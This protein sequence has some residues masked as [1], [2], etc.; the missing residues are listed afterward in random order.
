MAIAAAPEMAS[1]SPAAAG[2][3]AGG[4][5]LRVVTGKHAGE[6]AALDGANTMVGTPG[7]DTALVVRRARGFFLARLGGAGVIRLN[8]ADIGPGTHATGKGDRIE[9]GGT[10]FELVAIDDTGP[11]GTNS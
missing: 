3:P 10:I 1:T 8:G 2:A 11:S 9:V 4:L 5:G 6:I 7:G